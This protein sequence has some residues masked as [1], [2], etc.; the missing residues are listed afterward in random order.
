MN[1]NDLLPIPKFADAEKNQVAKYLS[2]IIFVSLTLNPIYCIVLIYSLSQPTLPLVANAILFVLQ[3]ISFFLLRTGQV[4]RASILYVTGAWLYFG[5]T[6]LIL[7]GSDSPA[8]LGFFTVVLMAGLLLDNRWAYFFTSLS[9]FYAVIVFFIETAG[10]LPEPLVRI[11]PLYLWGSFVLAIFVLIIIYELSTEKLNIAL[12]GTRKNVEALNKQNHLLQETQQALRANLLELSRT[13]SALRLS[14]K[15]LKTVVQS[16][17]VIVW[18]S[19]IEGRMTLLEG[20][21]LSSV[22]IQAN[23]FHGESIFDALGERVQDLEEKIKSVLQGETIVSIENLKGHIFETHFSPLIEDGA[24]NGIIGV[25]IDITERVQ[26]QDAMIHLQKTESL[27]VLA[28]GI[29]HDFN[30]LLVGILGQASVGLYKMEDSHPSR[31]HIEK[32]ILASEKAGRLIHQLL[33]YSGRGQFKLESFDLNELVRENINLFQTALSQKTDFQISL[34]DVPLIIDGDLAQLQQVI[35]N[36]IINGAEAISQ[37]SGELTVKTSPVVVTDS[38]KQKDWAGSSL[39]A[40]TYAGLEISDTGCGMTS[41]ILK[42]IFDPFF[43]T[44]DTGQGLG[45]AAVQGIVNGHDGSLSV[46]SEVNVGTTFQVLL[47]LSAGHGAELKHQDSFSTS[48]STDISTVLQVDDDPSVCE[49]LKDIFSA[50]E[51]SIFSS[52]TRQ[53]GIETFQQNH[54]NIDLIILDMTMPGISLE[55]TISQ[56]KTINSKTP[57]IL[58]SGFDRDEVARQIDSKLIQ[59]FIS[60]PYSIDLFLSQLMQILAAIPAEK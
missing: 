60:K 54:E 44:K 41:D 46:S 27:G 22:N 23:Q 9:V 28:G 37:R 59:G 50:Q 20:K 12:E 36:L 18:T 14:Q 39:L 57:I 2:I 31:K 51:I 13:E 6:V 49:T 3:C 53:Q 25:A 43:T 42:K 19:D 58:S 29:A 7:G 5:G 47:P 52:L 15:H 35:M 4:N 55:A 34:H 8:V 33:A 48:L 11:T 30:N 10:R 40:G 1:L 26:A 56:L 38:S 32:S 45:L 21:T 16:A 17:P 24:V